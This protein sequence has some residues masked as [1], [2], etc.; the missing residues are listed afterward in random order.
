MPEVRRRDLERAR[1]IVAEHKRAVDAKHLDIVRHQATLE[2]TLPEG[3][4]E[5]LAEKRT[6]LEEATNALARLERSA[7]AVKLLRET[8]EGAYTDAQRTLMKPVYDEAM[9]LLRV[10]RPGT[11]FTMHNDTLHLASVNRNGIEEEFKDLS[12]GAREQLALVVRIALAKV[13]AR[14]RLG[15]PLVLDDVLGWTDDR[16]LRGMLN[17]LEQT[18]RD[19]QVILLTCHP[20]RFRGIEGAASFEVQRP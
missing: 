13:F 3:R 4:Y 11:T 1:Q 15:L 5:K 9:P 8:T 19:M 12:G 20:G 2:A 6:E 7:R 17:V 16:R 10:I 14:Q 18:S